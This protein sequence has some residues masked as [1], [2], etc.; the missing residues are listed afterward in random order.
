MSL[1]FTE[2]RGDENAE[3]GAAE[4]GVGYGTDGRTGWPI[5]VPGP[6]WRSSSASPLSSRVPLP[7]ISPRWLLTLTEA[8]CPAS[9]RFFYLVLSG[10]PPAPHLSPHSQRRSAHSGWR[11]GNFDRNMKSKSVDISIG[12]R[13]H[14]TALWSIWY[15]HSNYLWYQDVQRHLPRQPFVRETDVPSSLVALF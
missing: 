7:C 3:V 9:P 15:S 1:R 10:P 13:Y 12:K 14:S 8:A 5:S 2:Q 4:V 6:V 11:V